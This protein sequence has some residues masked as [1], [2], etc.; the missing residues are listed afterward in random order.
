MGSAARGMRDAGG[1]TL[2]F[3]ADQPL[4]LGALG[5][6]V[7]A[8]LAAVLPSTRTEDE[9]MG[10]LSD[11][12]RD[13]AQE[14]GGAALRGGTKVASDMMAAAGEAAEREGL[15]SDSAMSAAERARSGVGD[16]AQRL[17]HVVEE[18]VS[19]GRDAA[20]RELGGGTGGD[21]RQVSGAGSEPRS[22]PATRQ[23]S[24]GGTQVERDLGIGTSGTAGEPG[25]AAVQPTIGTSPRVHG[26]D[27]RGAR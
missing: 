7:G 4:L 23:D 19:A 11:D 6:S 22:G 1:S 10:E 24:P 15:T 21:E 17:R 12:L 25:R 2:G 8:L 20:Q 9:L 18:T 26:Y 14:A 3:L 5:V 27:E 13:R 16:A